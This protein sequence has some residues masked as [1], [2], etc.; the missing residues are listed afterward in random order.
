MPE[1]HWLDIA[2][3]IGAPADV[4][5]CVRDA[6]APDGRTR[7]YDASL[8]GVHA[9]RY[10][11]SGGSVLA[12]LDVRSD[13]E[14]PQ[15]IA[16]LSNP[17]SKVLVLSQAGQPDVRSYYWFP[18]DREPRGLVARIH[19]GPHVTS[20]GT[21]DLIDRAWLNNGYGVLKTNYVGG[22]RK[23][24]HAEQSSVESSFA[25][26]VREVTLSVE[27]LYEQ[28]GLG[29]LPLIIQGDS[30]GGLIALKVAEQ[31]QV[32][33][34]LVLWSPSCDA[35]LA[36]SRARRLS[37]ELTY[38]VSSMVIPGDLSSQLGQIGC[39]TGEFP[40]DPT[41]I[42]YSKGDPSLGP[43]I[44]D[45]ISSLQDAGNRNVFEITGVP[46]HVGKFDAR[47]APVIDKIADR[48]S[49]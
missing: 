43:G 5:D 30:F 27:G 15:I 11:A 16:Q 19:G 4:I 21:A 44:L 31:S 20:S 41:Y 12:Y 24:A 36:E 3:L 45:A 17:L 1:N 9:I 35:E 10:S 37:E 42:V 47:S 14:P 22:S 34:A 38:D 32:P 48:I 40:T 18:E 39:R 26:M 46:F 13:C 2:Q 28:E 49:Q 29:D 6:V 23:F 25:A 7:V 8:K 33:E